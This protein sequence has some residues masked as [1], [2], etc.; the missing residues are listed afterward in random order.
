MLTDGTR[1]NAVAQA[2]HDEADDHLRDAKRR[3][4]KRSTNA[5]DDAP[6][7]DALLP[8]EPFSKQ[9]AEYGAEETSDLVYGDNGPWSEEL[10][11]APSMVSI[12]GKVRVNATLM[13][14]PD[15]TP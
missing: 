1:V 9:E 6:Q 8:A 10:P 3:S 4:L 12:S 13:S 7:H 5:E 15:V 11:P 2:C 14:R